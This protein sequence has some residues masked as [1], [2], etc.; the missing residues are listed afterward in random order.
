M[1]YLPDPPQRSNPATFAALAD[2]FLAALPGFGD[3]METLALAAT[4]GS[5]QGAYAGG[6][7]YAKGETVVSG[8]VFYVSM[9]NANTGNTPASSPAWW[10]SPLSAFLTASAIISASQGGTGITSYTAGDLIIASG[11]TT[12]AKLADVA[13]GNALISGGV[14]V[15]PSWGKIGLTTHVSGTLPIANG[16]TG[17]STATFCN[18]TTNVTGTLPVANGGTGVTA[19]TGSGNNVLSTSPTLVTPNLGTPTSGT[20][21]NCTGLP[22]STGVTGLGLNVATALGVAVGSAGAVVTFN[23]ALGTPASG[24]LT[25]CTGLPI[26]AGSTGTLPVSRGGTGDTTYSNG[27]LL[28]GNSTGS[29]LTKA[30]LTAGTGI[31]ITNGAGSI[32]IAAGLPMTQSG[33]TSYSI[34]TTAASGSNNVVF[35][36]GAGAA[37]ISGAALGNTLI[38]ASAGAAVTNGD[39]NTL[40]GANA[41][42]AITTGLNNTIVGNYVSASAE[43]SMVA[44]SDGAGTRRLWHDGGD[45][46]VSHNT[47]ASAANAF[48]DSATNALRRST[49]SLRY[50]RDVEDLWPDESAKLLKLKPVFYRSLCD[51]DPEAWSY[52]GV[53]AEEADKLGLQ[54]LVQYEYAPE[55]YGEPDENGERWP[56]PDAQKVPGGFA[57]DRMTVLLLDLVQRQE[58]RIAAL[59][60]KVEAIEA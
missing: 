20:L 51:A 60:E 52:Y 11:A 8:G 50:K 31:A 45:A 14:G 6:T 55:D 15:V 28:I 54:R 38:G 17:A 53:I 34:S 40:I 24:T 26:G 29:T 12:L 30:T 35:G 41:G 10:Y 13:T 36:S 44:L 27:Q 49:S 37:F 3:V 48:L 58:A 7:T 9:Q 57:Y 18:L 16:G 23:G 59:E 5:F 25:N 21:T 47:T 32:T 2:P 19:S 1:S 4:D 22:L 39:N 43:S 33:G 56:K 42:N 46:F